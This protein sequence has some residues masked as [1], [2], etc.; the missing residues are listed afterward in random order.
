LGVALMLLGSAA[1]FSTIDERVLGTWMA[2]GGKFPIFPFV[3][4]FGGLW[5]ALGGRAKGTE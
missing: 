3:L 1:I 4:I 5:L 2:I